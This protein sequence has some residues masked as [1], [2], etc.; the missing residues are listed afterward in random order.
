MK[1]VSSGWSPPLPDDAPDGAP[2][3]SARLG[4]VQ[5]SPFMTQVTVLVGIALLMTV[6]VYGLASVFV[7]VV[8]AKGS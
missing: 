6:G 7:K 3:A 1:G 2:S 4:T 5:A 8:E